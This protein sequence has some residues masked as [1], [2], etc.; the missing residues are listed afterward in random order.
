MNTPYPAFS[1][2]GA[3]NPPPRRRRDV[4]WDRILFQPP[5]LNPRLVFDP[6]PFRSQLLPRSG[7]SR[8]PFGR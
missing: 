6:L 2:Q 8:P 4:T 5:T 3:E 1:L 7:R